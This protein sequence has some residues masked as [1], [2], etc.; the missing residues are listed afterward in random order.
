MSFINIRFLSVVGFGLPGSGGGVA[1]IDSASTAAL[2]T[3]S[4]STMFCSCSDIPCFLPFT[5]LLI[6]SLFFNLDPTPRAAKPAIIILSKPAW[7]NSLSSSSVNMEATEATPA[8][9]SN[10]LPTILCFLSNTRFSFS[11]FLRRPSCSPVW[12]ILSNL[13]FNSLN[14]CVSAKLPL[15]TMGLVSENIS[16]LCCK[17][18]LNA[19]LKFCLA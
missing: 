4:G 7:L 17:L 13:A 8:P 11:S 3:L 18:R 2:P 16:S 5:A 19:F 1:S 10:T 14:L 15:A 12:S 9:P 6:R